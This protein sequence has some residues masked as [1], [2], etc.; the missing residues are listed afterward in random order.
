MILC[1]SHHITHILVLN[2]NGHGHL[3]EQHIYLNIYSS[4]KSVEIHKSDE[5]ALEEEPRLGAAEEIN[6][7]MTGRM[8]FCVNYNTSYCG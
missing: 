2:E 7:W 4:K 3:N 1:G 5:E 8:A 6:G